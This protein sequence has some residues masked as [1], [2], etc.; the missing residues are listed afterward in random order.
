MRYKLGMRWR[1]WLFD[2]WSWLMALVKCMHC[3]M[4]IL[5]VHS[6]KTDNDDIS[7]KRQRRTTGHRRQLDN[8]GRRPR[9][10]QAAGGKRIHHWNGQKYVLSPYSDCCYFTILFCV[11][12]IDLS[13]SIPLKVGKGWELYLYWNQLVCPAFRLSVC[14]SARCFLICSTICNQNWYSIHYHEPGVPRKDGIA[15]F[16]VKVER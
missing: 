9:H 4:S 10:G 1:E 11:F 7:G 5:S 15:A 14:V 13:F 8:V 12:P 16:K 6:P 2:Q 3:W